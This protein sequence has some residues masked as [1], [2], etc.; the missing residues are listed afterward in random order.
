MA[1]IIDLD[2]FTFN[3]DTLREVSELVFDAVIKGPD[4][5]MLH[6]VYPNVVTQREVGFVSRGGLVGKAN[7]GCNP[8]PQDWAIDTRK[9]K[10]NPVAWE[11][12]IA[13]CWTDLQATAAVYSLNTGIS[14]PDFT[15]TDY[16][17][18][19]QEVLTTSMNQFMYRFIWFSDVAA[20][21]QKSGGDITDGIDVDYFNLLDGLFKKMET[22]VTGSPTQLVVITENQAATYDT[23]RVEG[24]DAFVYLKQ[25]YRR[26]PIALRNM[27]SKMY[28]S[29]Q[30]FYDAYVEYLQDA[31]ALETT[32]KNLVNGMEVVSYNGI[33]VV[34]LPIWD[35]IIFNYLNTG[36]KAIDPNRV[37]LTAPEVLAVGVDDPSA[38]DDMQSWHDRKTRQVMVEAMGQADVQ[39]ADDRLFVIGI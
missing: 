6:T 12:L 5:N 18:I 4:L 20:A 26:A 16:M 31:K 33:P 19:V 32:Y 34:P 2:K 23:Q 37:V 27:A 24:D 17:A 7:Q 39:L 35:D 15:N 3:G 36:T 8:T 1:R 10:F 38:F 28:M 22:V 11:I 21:N 25:L 9:V 30:F 13:A 14:I 29:T